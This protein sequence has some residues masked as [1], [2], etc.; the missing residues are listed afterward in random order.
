MFE[1][2]KND[3][4]YEKYTVDF[5]WEEIYKEIE[6]PNVKNIEKISFPKVNKEKIKEILLKYEFSE[7]RIDNQLKRFDEIKKQREQQTLF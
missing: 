4:K 2:I 1:A 6:R 5:D 7:D 3:E